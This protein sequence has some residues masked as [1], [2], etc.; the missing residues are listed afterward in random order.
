MWYGERIFN[1]EKTFNI[2]HTNWTKEDDMPPERF[3]SQPLDG[4]F[5]IDLKDWNELLNRYYE[6][7]G[8]DKK[9]GKPV[10]ET[11]KRLN[12]EKLQ[13]KLELNGKLS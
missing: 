5:K 4:K 10:K 7:H 1:L 3:L 11:F 12:L 8:W 13:N 2:L 6:L 9:T